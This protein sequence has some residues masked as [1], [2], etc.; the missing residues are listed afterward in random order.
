[1][2][3]D[4]ILAAYRKAVGFLNH[5]LIYLVGSYFDRANAIVAEFSIWVINRCQTHHISA[6]LN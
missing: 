4:V 1:M 3:I 6:H 2:K 5:C